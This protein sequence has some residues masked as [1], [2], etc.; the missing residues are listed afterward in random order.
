MLVLLSGLNSAH[1]RNNIFY[2]QPKPIYK[3]QD[4]VLIAI[5][6]SSSRTSSIRS[7]SRH[8]DFEDI[9]VPFLGGFA[10]AAPPH[11]STEVPC[12]NGC[13]SGRIDDAIII[14]DIKPAPVVVCGSGNNASH[15]NVVIELKSHETRDTINCSEDVD[16]SNRI[17]LSSGK[18]DDGS[19]DTCD[20][21]RY[22]LD[23]C[24]FHSWRAIPTQGGVVVKVT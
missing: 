13:C 9:H 24:R 2:Q 1:P 22:T 12:N 17:S 20:A 3:L 8:P 4:F 15:P 7:S 10:Q 6:Y 23:I 14:T 5:S 18:N 21:D 16:D 19:F 11:T